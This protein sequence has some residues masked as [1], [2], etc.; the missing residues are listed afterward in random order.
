VQLGAI[1]TQMR[2]GVLPLPVINLHVMA[3]KDGSQLSNTNAP[4]LVDQIN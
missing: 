4:V 2:L 3:V 1:L